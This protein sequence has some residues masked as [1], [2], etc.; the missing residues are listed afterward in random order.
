V[1]RVLFIMAPLAAR[2]LVNRRPDS[3]QAHFTMGYV[4]RYAGVLEDAT[5][6]CDKA[7]RLD[8]GNYFFRSC[9]W[10]FMYMGNTQRAWE[11]VGL[12]AGSEWANWATPSI[13]LR[14]GKISEAREAVRKCRRLRGTIATYWRQQ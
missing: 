3:A 6:E 11:Y 5:Q 12:D 14:E 4:D 7:L 8:P 10:A 2:A 13:L 9:A 1:I